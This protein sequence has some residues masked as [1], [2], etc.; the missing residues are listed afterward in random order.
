MGSL[1]ST[2]RDKIRQS[3]LNMLHAILKDRALHEAAHD[4]PS[5]RRPLIHFN[6]GIFSNSLVQ[7][8]ILPRQDVKL[9]PNGLI[10]PL[11]FP[12]TNIPRTTASATTRA[13]TEVF[14][15]IQKR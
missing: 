11:H 7:N 4:A 2:I 15:R 5:E 8:R 12:L 1:L 9:G 3:F 6:Q 13:M 10:A 14:L